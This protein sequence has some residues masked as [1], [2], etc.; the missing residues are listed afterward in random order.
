MV[1]AFIFCIAARLELFAVMRF[2]RIKSISRYDGVGAVE[3][4]DHVSG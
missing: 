4:K 2:A 1:W 3:V